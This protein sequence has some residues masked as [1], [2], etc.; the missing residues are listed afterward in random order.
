MEFWVLAADARW[1]NEALQTVVQKGLSDQIK[2]ELAA[3]DEPKG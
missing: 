3:R 1:N 2:D